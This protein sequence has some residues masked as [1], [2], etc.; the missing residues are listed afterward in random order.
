MLEAAIKDF[1]RFLCSPEPDY[2]ENT[3]ESTGTVI[4]LFLIIFLFEI[5]V[6]G[7][8]FTLIGME[9]HDHKM[10]ELMKNM[11]F[12]QIFILAVIMAPVVEELIF[13]YYINKVWLCLALIPLLLSG[14]SVYLFLTHPSPVVYIISAILIFVSLL[15]IG[16]MFREP[17][18]LWW[19]SGFRAY[20]PYI[21]Y[22]SATAFAFVHIFNFDESMSWYFTPILV[23]PQ[24]VI[25]LYLG[26]LR[27]RNGLIYSILIHAINNA[28]PMLL[29]MVAPENF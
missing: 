9:S 3:P 11:A 22:L 15:F 27:I 24:F 20:Y 25:G 1:Y 10:D 8:L 29:I 23:F 4:S 14:T 21:F 12:Y 6:A 18:L 19:K 2:K 26:Y 5:I 16:S 7:L 28:I 17:V 13:R